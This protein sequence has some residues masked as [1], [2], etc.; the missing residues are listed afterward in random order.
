MSVDSLKLL[1]AQIGEFVDQHE[2][3]LL[4]LQDKEQ[5]LAEAAVRLRQYEQERSEIKARLERILGRLGS[6]DL[7]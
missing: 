5:E 4:R 6:L 3:V 2:R 7:T 1:E